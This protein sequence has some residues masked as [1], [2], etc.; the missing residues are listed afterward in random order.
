MA[1]MPLLR[2]I[3]I[4]IANWSATSIGGGRVFVTVNSIYRNAVATGIQYSVDGGPWTNAI[5]WDGTLPVI[6]SISGLA[7]GN[8]SIRLR[9]DRG[10]S[11][12][13]TASDP[14]VVAV[15]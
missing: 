7:Q 9:P 5:T 4:Q 6:F 11:Q 15:P 8:R 12:P 3:P 10:G 1:K 13:D 2:R 14:I